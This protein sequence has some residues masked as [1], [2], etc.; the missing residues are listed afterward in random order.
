MCNVDFASFY[1]LLSGNGE[2]ALAF[3]FF[4]VRG[5]FEFRALF[6]VAP[7]VPFLQKE[8]EEGQQHQ[9][10]CSPLAWMVV[11]SLCQSDSIL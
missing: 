11:M 9:I 8:E 4:I 2:D 1:T 5:K 7:R 3:K 10:V 6:S